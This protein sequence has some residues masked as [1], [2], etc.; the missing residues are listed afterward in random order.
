MRH[1]SLASAWL[2]GWTLGL[3]AAMAPLSHAAEVSVET[4]RGHA[5]EQKA[6]L[7]QSL[8]ELTQFESGSREPDELDRIASYLRDRLAA[9]GASVRVVEP[10]PAEV[11][12]LSD[13]PDRLAKMVRGTFVGTGTKSVLLIAHMDTVYRRGSLANQPF[14]L[15]GDRAYG[16]GIADDRHGIAVILHSLA[17]LKALGFQ[18]YGRITVLLNGDEEI[19]SPGSRATLAR[20]G[21]EHDAVLSFEGGGSPVRD[22]LTLA[23]SGVG[24]AELTVRG[25]A[26]HAGNAPELGVN[27]LVELSHQILQLRNLSDPAR[28]LK[29]NWTLS[30]AGTVSGMIPP[31]AKA[32]AS[33]RVARLA[34]FDFIEQV[35]RDRIQSKL[36]PEAQVSVSLERRFLPLEATDASKA[37]GEHARKIY[38]EIGLQLELQHDASGGATDAANAAVRTKAPVLE[39]LGLRGY[40]AH[41]IDAEYVMVSSIEPRLYLT[42]RLI[43]DIALGKTAPQ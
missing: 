21:A 25:R 41:T 17:I 5:V 8:R 1:A 39:G 32:S 23:T 12:R 19:S 6:P 18:E 9:L 20:L 36:L 43:M 35:L 4:L 15:E 24:R 11:V 31:I 28:G 30:Q 7:I 14:R 27:A 40:G 37:L 10:D 16:L 26:S 42:T 13:T 2:I 33:V 38:R 34:D 29:V 3:P 22:R